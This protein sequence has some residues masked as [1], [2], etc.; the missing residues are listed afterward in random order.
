MEPWQG[1]KSTTGGSV[2]WVG[3][4]G[5]VFGVYVDVC[6]FE[7]GYDPPEDLIDLRVATAK[8]S[9]PL[10]DSCVVS[11]D[12]EMVAGVHEQ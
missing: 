11:V 12:E 3:F 4:A 9:P 10:D 6:L 1:G 2:R 7:E 8:V 5:D